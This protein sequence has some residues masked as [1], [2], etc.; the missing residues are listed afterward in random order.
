MAG[1]GNLRFHRKRRD[2]MIEVDLNDNIR[3]RLDDWILSKYGH[4]TNE[5]SSYHVEKAILNMMND[6]EAGESFA[7][8]Y[9]SFDDFEELY[10]FEIQRSVT[11]YLDKQEAMK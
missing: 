9:V 4:L 1:A 5:L 6:W 2:S 11:R 3:Q 10:N 8:T 7:P